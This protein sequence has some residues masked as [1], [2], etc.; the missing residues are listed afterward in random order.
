MDYRPLGDSGLLV[1]QICL[2]TMTFGEQNTEDEGHAQLDMALDA[3]I[4]FIDTAEMYPIPASEGT[5]GRTE[6]IIGSWFHQRGGRERVVLASKIIGPGPFNYI[7][8]RLDFSPASLRTALEGSLRRL[9]TDYIDLYQLH[10]PSRRTNV[11]GVRGYPDTSEETW[12]DDFPAV[13]HTLLA[14]IKEGKIRCFGLSNETPWGLQHCINLANTQG[15]PRCVS[16]QNPYNLLNRLF[17]IGL[18]EIS[19]REGVGLLAYSP[20]AFGTLTGKYAEGTASPDS[21]LR[22]FAE[23]PRLVRYNGPSSQ[24]ALRRYV[25]LARQSDLSPAGMALAFVHSRPFLTSN[26][27][28]ATGTDQL[29]ENI[30][31]LR[32]VLP[33]DVLDEIEVIHRAIPDP[34]P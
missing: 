4:N 31:S 30:E 27:I 32:I 10:W 24:E 17:E 12:T 26:I 3:G 8:S 14:F 25:A 16:I 9:Q 11:F 34:A 22:K 1:S 29:R 23:S 5:Y 19:R 33:R 18:A 7:R 21:R 15:F 2:G 20:L 13:L 6:E 28:G